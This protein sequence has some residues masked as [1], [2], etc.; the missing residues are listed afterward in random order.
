VSLAPRLAF[1]MARLPIPPVPTA[2]GAIDPADHEQRPTIEGI[3]A[4][5]ATALPSAAGLERRARM[6]NRYQ[7]GMVLACT[8]LVGL[9]AF[10]A[11]DPLYSTAWPGVALA[12]VLSVVLCLR[13]RSFADLTQAATLIAGGCA[14]AIAVAIG[15]GVGDPSR[16]LPTAVAMLVVAVLAV[17]FGVVGPNT[18]TSPLIMRAGEILEYLLIVCIIPLALWVLNLYSLARDM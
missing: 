17:V 8:G 5:G 15:V 13:G 9:G 14:T 7:S 16:A 11:A 6:A 4:I 10:F 18:E 12:G 3:G 2:G 1:A